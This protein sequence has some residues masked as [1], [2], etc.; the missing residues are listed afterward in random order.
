[1]IT[2]MDV[3]DKQLQNGDLIDHLDC[4]KE[5]IIFR[6]WQGATEEKVGAHFAC[7][8]IWS[9]EIYFSARVG[10]SGGAVSEEDFVNFTSDIYAPL[11]EFDMKCVT[12]EQFQR[13]GDRLKEIF[14]P[15]SDRHKNLELSI[16]RLDFN[17]MAE[18]AVKMARG[19]QLALNPE[20]KIPLSMPTCS[21][22]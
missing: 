12:D 17:V 11:S 2:V 15:F 9:R 1:M 22:L 6:K 7:K 14:S 4:V 10:K 13:A 3:I 16:L 18:V 19:D 8:P 5:R 20:A 21:K